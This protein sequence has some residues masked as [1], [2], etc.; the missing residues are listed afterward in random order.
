M[1]KILRKMFWKTTRLFLWFCA[2]MLGASA[3]AT[4][5]VSDP[6]R[7]DKYNQ[8]IQ[9]LAEKAKENQPQGIDAASKPDNMK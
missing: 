9:S 3:L 8:Y 4:Y 6:E 2:I 7:L 5:L 1:G